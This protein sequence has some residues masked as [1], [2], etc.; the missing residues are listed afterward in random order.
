MATNSR[1]AV[2]TGF[3]VLSP[4]GSTPAAFWD[5]L[6]AG[7]TGIRK[8]QHFDAS[9]LPCSI[10]GEIPDFVAK[11]AIEKN[12]RKLLN[13]MGRPVQLGVI[14][15]QNAM[16]DAGLARG[17]V[18]K[19]RL[20]VEFACVMGATEINDLA[21]ASKKSSHGPREPVDMAA[22]GRDGL[23]DITPMWMLK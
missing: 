13:A 1:R 3:G 9:S 15:A 2:L 4:I 6:L 7:K 10:G 8:L 22:W 21:A 18:P 17:S 14:A 19:E 11:N 20:G 5:A 12:F 16:H 23:T